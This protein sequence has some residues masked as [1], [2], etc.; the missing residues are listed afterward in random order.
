MASAHA[1]NCA[2]RVP[3]RQAQH[4][5]VTGHSLGGQRHP[6]RRRRQLE[7]CRYPAQS[8][9]PSAHQERRRPGHS[10]SPSGTIWSRSGQL[11]RS[12]RTFVPCN[13]LALACPCSGDHRGR[14]SEIWKRRR[15][16]CG[17]SSTGIC[18][19]LPSAVY[20]VG[21]CR[22]HACQRGTAIQHFFAVLK[23]PNCH[24]RLCIHGSADW[25]E[26]MARLIERCAPCCT[27][28]LPVRVPAPSLGGLHDTL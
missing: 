26:C 4:A 8:P 17:R 20:T 16:A 23:F 25:S 15:S 19:F 9:R 6:H 10:R 24:G 7:E 14:D 18:D 12:L 3:V 13:P 27:Q 21:P 28:A 22:W 1:S 11:S 5:A 2:H